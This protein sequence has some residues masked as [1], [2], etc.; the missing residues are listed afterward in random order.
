M[1]Y[2]F[3][4]L[5]VPLVGAVGLAVDYSSS[6]YAKNRLDASAMAAAATAANS[7]RIALQRTGSVLNGQDSDAFNEGK[8]RGV[9]TFVAH[10][11]KVPGFI[12]APT[13]N[14]TRSGQILTSTVAY[15]AVTPTT[16]GQ[17][18]G[19]TNVSISGSSSAIAT[20]E[21][22]PPNGYVIQESFEKMSLQGNPWN[23]VSSYN[24]WTV[25]SG[26]GLEIDSAC[27]FLCP[28]PD[29][30]QVAQLDSYNN[31]AITKKIYLPPGQYELRYFYLAA[32]NNPVYMPVWIC[33]SQDSD[34]DWANAKDD[35]GY[36]QTNKISVYLDPAMGTTSA[37]LTWSYAE[38]GAVGQNLLDSC[39]SSGY[40]WI[41]RS[42]PI[43]VNAAGNYWLTFTAL[44]A[45]DGVGGAIDNIRLCVNSCPGTVQ[46]NFYWSAYSLFFAESFDG[47]APPFN[48]TDGNTTSYSQH[49]TLDRSGVNLLWSRPMA[50]WTTYPQ[51]QIPWIQTVSRGRVR[52]NSAVKPQIRWLR[53]A[54]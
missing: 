41:E 23:V 15:A 27:T 14:L 20:I 42:V 16:F 11:T 33:G 3:A 37:P 38:G 52:S 21:D 36:A 17:L 31:S 47:A 34:V 50:G 2:L 5:L 44:G 8:R 40:K 24:G 48:V 19:V 26:A 35:W 49:V 10:S 22:S 7:A 46:E 39:V 29:G 54:S 53:V 25:A 9:A 30:N 1:S 28:A 51:D 6:L 12:S 13:I 4:L 32:F 18:F 45:S 43:T